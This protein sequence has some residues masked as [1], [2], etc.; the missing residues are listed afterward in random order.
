MLALV[1]ST[2][3]CNV[4]NPIQT[5]LKKGPPRLDFQ[6]PANPPPPIIVEPL[7]RRKKVEIEY[8]LAQ[9]FFKPPQALARSSKSPF[10]PQSVEHLHQFHKPWRPEDSCISQLA[11]WLTDGTQRTCVVTGPHGVGKQTL[12]RLVAK[13]CAFELTVVAPKAGFQLLDLVMA[14]LKPRALL[15]VPNLD[16][17]IECGGSVKQ[18][19]DFL[20][21]FD[22][23]RGEK[24]PLLI[25]TANSLYAKGHTHLAHLKSKAFQVR[26]FGRELEERDAAAVVKRARLVAPHGT[27]LFFWTNEMIEKHWLQS[28]EAR[29]HTD[30]RGAMLQ[31][32]FW[33]LGKAPEDSV[34][35]LNPFDSAYAV[36]R[37]VAG[38]NVLTSPRL[39]ECATTD[40][41][42]TIDLLVT[43][44]PTLALNRSVG[45][46]ERTVESEVEA[47]E[48]LEALERVSEFMDSVCAHN[49]CALE[50]S[51]RTTVAT[52]AI[53]LASR[54]KPSNTNKHRGR[55]FKI[56]RE[57]YKEHKV[58]D[59][60]KT[61]RI[62]ASS[63]PWLGFHPFEILERL[64][65]L[66][67]EHLDG[68]RESV[69]LPRISC[70]KKNAKVDGQVLRA[71]D[72]LLLLS[73]EKSLPRLSSSVKRACEQQPLVV[74]S[75]LPSEHLLRRSET[76]ML[77]KRVRDFGSSSLQETKPK[78][79]TKCQ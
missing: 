2:V 29:G 21:A 60:L 5:Q 23:K 40:A 64:Q 59:F 71:D 79:G 47:L 36:V 8:C 46:E 50:S 63:A 32:Q 15:L 24:S 34:G 48:S 67:T 7:D 16:C 39:D 35:A 19:S 11:W 53:V 51:A 56:E 77:S 31:M 10:E 27:A 28:L 42:Q 61:V 68:L 13:R 26:A 66:T 6:A 69:A 49:T 62:T 37:H 41:Q 75:R 54:L 55:F 18:W 38:T 3:V 76:S 4:P 73:C 14:A 9:E 25:F 43:N 44:A 17:D 12:V 52:A 30:I 20:A 45:A 65:Y 22:T 74:M 58:H 1:L 72:V 78:R 33:A 70:A 57:P